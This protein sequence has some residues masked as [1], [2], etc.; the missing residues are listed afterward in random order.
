MYR[1]IWIYHFL[2]L[3]EQ[4]KCY[5]IYEHTIYVL[6][7][8]WTYHLCVTSYMN[9]PSGKKLLL[10]SSKVSWV[11][12]MGILLTVSWLYHMLILWS[13]SID[14]T[15]EHCCLM[16]IELT[17][18]MRHWFHSYFFLRNFPRNN[19]EAKRKKLYRKILSVCKSIDGAAILFFFL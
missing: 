6:R 10:F 3:F 13:F 16:P 7:H 14:I 17:H 15:H 5:V 1:H 8:I 11:K 18:D 19:C 9:G 4:T 2:S 12:S